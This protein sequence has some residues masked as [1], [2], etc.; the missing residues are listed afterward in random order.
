MVVRAA[1]GLATG[2]IGVR[3]KRAGS[4]GGL[5]VARGE[6]LCCDDTELDPRVNREACHALGVRSLMITPL[7]VDGAVDGALRVLSSRTGAFT[8]T[9]VGTLQIL[10]ECLG[11]VIQRAGDAELLRRSEAQYRLL[12]AAHPLAMWVYEIGTLRFLAVNDSAVAQYGYSK[13]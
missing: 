12:F 13:P 7:R 11:V 1:C 4:L 10:A 5:S 3:V 8:P 6:I 9:D 2:Q